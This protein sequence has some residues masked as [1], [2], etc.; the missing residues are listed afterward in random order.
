[1]TKNASGVMS[2]TSIVTCSSRFQSIVSYS[3]SFKIVTFCAIV[4]ATFPVNN[5][6]VEESALNVAA[7]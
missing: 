7:W 2:L 5:W 4:S 3:L 1:M 6:T